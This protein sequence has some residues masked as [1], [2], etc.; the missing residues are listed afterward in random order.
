MTQF[1]VIAPN[2]VP[3]A[4]HFRAI[5]VEFTRTGALS[6]IEPE[7]PAV[8]TQVALIPTEAALIATSRAELPSDAAVGMI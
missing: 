6:P 8:P 3:V 7:I 5:P 1:A 2:L 4:S